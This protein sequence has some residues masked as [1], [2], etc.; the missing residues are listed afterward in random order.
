V[1]DT[2][3]SMDSTGQ[4]R[5]P[6]IITI[7]G[8]AASGK[9]T[10]GDALAHRLNYL[11]FDTGAM[12]RAVTW[13]ALEQGID[14]HD[15]EAVGALA[16]S[17]SIDI[18]PPLPE[19]ADGRQVTVLVGD[20]DVTWAIRSPEVDRNVSVVAAN[21]RVRNALTIHQRRISK[22]FES[23]AAEKEGLVMVGRDIGTVVLPDAPLKIYLDASVEERANRRYQE[24]LRRGKEVAYE[25]VLA[26][27]RR[28]DEIDSQ[29]DIAPLRPA[30]DAHILD[31]QHHSADEM[32]DQIVEL[33]ERAAVKST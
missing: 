32:V 6:R 13:S 15:L 24:L 33:V 4:D 25:Q 22:R 30:Y 28:R 8:P 9:S 27:L 23:G 26:D 18:G 19:I 11:Y 17:L 7:D 31:S 1:S 10:V 20:M 2:N 21:G 3:N 29:R 14:L 5:Q 16:E 12:Y